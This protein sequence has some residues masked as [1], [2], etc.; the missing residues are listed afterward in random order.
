MNP[1]LEWKTAENNTFQTS[2]SNFWE[3]MTF[4]SKVM[5]WYFCQKRNMFSFF[6]GTDQL[7]SLNIYL[8]TPKTETH[9]PRD[10]FSY[11]LFRARFFLK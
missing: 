7:H 3:R 2:L 5:V 11:S 10:M 4:R 1:S 9:K 8:Q 6:S